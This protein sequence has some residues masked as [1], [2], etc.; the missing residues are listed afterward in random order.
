MSQFLWEN[1][2]RK[3]SH[4][5]PLEPLVSIH[6]IAG[7]RRAAQRRENERESHPRGKGLRKADLGRDEADET[8]I[9]NCIM[10]DESEQE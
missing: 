4:H 10:R 1:S 3:A 9:E 2:V 7:H 8:Q 6:Q 5:R